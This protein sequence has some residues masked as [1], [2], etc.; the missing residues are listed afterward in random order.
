MGKRFDSKKL[1]EFRKDN[2]DDETTE[3]LL[4]VDDPVLWAE[5]HLHD[6]DLG[7]TPFVCKPQFRDVL[8]DSA[9]NRAA[10][11][12]RQQGKCSCAHTHFQLYDGSWPTA[13]EVY[14][15]VGELGAFDI[16]ATNCE[17]YKHKVDRGIIK[18]N[19]I[20]H[21]IKVATTSGHETTNTSN[22]PYFIW[23]NSWETP[24]WIEG[25]NVRVDD[26][27]A[28]TRNLSSC[29]VK[30]LESQLQPEESELLGY[31]TGDGS[32]S[33][34][35][36]KFTSVDIELI[37]RINVI[38]SNLKSNIHLQPTKAECDYL[39]VIH[40]K[41][42]HNY[43]PGRTSWITDFTK[44]HELASTLSK[45]KKVPK[46]VFT[47]DDETIAAFLG[48]Y[49]ST[50][51]WIC[52]QKTRNTT[53]IGIC[54]ASKDLIYGTRTLLLRL[55]IQSRVH[56]KKVKYDGSFKDAWQLTIQDARDIAQF[57]SM[58]PIVHIKKLETLSAAV[59]KKNNSNTDTIPKGVWNYVN[60][61]VEERKWSY[62]ELLRDS[63][64]RHERIR[65]G[66][67]PNRSKFRSQTARLDD[68]FLKAIGASDIMWDTVKKVEDKGKE[69]TYAIEV[70][71]AH[72][73]LTDNFITHNTVHLCV[74]ILHTA[75]T[76]VRSTILVFVPEKK[77]MNRMLEIMS[78]LLRGT[79]LQG[80]FRM[81]T[82]KRIKD[83][84]EPEYDYEIK[85][86]TGSVARFFFMAQKP[87][88]ARGQTGSDIYV[89]EA[90]YLPEKAWPVINGIIKA[91]P[92]IPLWA[93]STPSG[94]EDTW[95]RNFCDR[96]S[97]P[98]NK[99]GT[100]YHLP[101]T[102]EKNWK[103][104][105][106]RL[107]DLFY[108]EVSW[109]L[110]V[111]AEWAEARGAIYKKEII[112]E[113]IE[114]GAIAGR[115]LPL[116]EIRSMLEYE[117]GDKF[118]GVDWN[119]PQN[120]VRIVEITTMFG[121]PWL[122]RHETITYN[123]YTQ[124]NAVHRILELHKE[125][126]YA[127]V[128]VD[129]GYGECVHKDTLINIPEGVKRIG[130]IEKKDIVMA[131]TGVFQ[132]VTG[133]V[134]RADK[135]DAYRII[136]SKCVPTITSSTHPFLVYQTTD[137]FN[138][139]KFSE[140]ALKWKRVDAINKEKD[141]IAIPKSEYSGSTSQSLVVDIK[142]LIGSDKGFRYDDTHVWYDNSYHVRERS[143]YSK[144]EIASITGASISTVQRIRKNIKEGCP[145]NNI[146]QE[147]YTEYQKL[148]DNYPVLIKHK[149]YINILSEDFQVIYGW[150][151]SEG[152][153][154][155]SSIEISQANNHN[156]EDFDR[157]IKSSIELFGVS[158]ISLYPRKD[159][160]K[161]ASDI[162]RLFVYGKII[163]RTFETIGGK[164]APNKHIYFPLLK[165]PASL[166]TLVK[167]IFVGD[168]HT[169]SNGFE[170]SITSFHLIY[171]LRQIL[172]DC[173]ILPSLYNIPPRNLRC[174]SQIRLDVS[175]NSNVM[176]KFV[177]FTGLKY[178]NRERTNRRKYI[179]ME[180]YML[181]PISKL[182]YIGKMSGLVDIEV[183]D[184]RS[185]C[186]NG[187]A[188]HN[189]QIELLQKGFINNGVDPA[190]LLNVVDSVK[191]EKMIIEYISPETHA[192]KRNEVTVRIKT[193][194]VGLVAKYLEQDLVLPRV[195]DEY[196]TGIIK[197]IRNFRRKGMTRD[198]GFLYSDKTHSLSALQ[199]CVHGYDKF[200]SS[201]NRQTSLSHDSM[202]TNDLTEVLQAKYQKAVATHAIAVGTFSN[203]HKRK[204]RTTGLS[205]GGTRRSIL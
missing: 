135:K 175:G 66:Y 191:K 190:N 31:L 187:I 78:N 91:N 107:R 154:N 34:H 35:T 93:S 75:G 64:N 194:I 11:V 89:D 85:A 67:S 77:H 74:D 71:G 173:G 109:K 26:R 20:K 42:S 121:K 44:E 8:R 45:N 137:R 134:V 12:G 192:R 4:E 130:N 100:E 1:A 203:R 2:L 147:L 176:N 113:A 55:N 39:F 25:S 158:N 168:G 101:S 164:L 139:S 69:Q 23:R 118:L 105:E 17:S 132:E 21:V 117:R 115:F 79:D 88:K 171:Q 97:D 98:K 15:S 138:D 196:K 185:F 48:A 179:E 19:G 116:E 14:E 110:E 183:K 162:T 95:F 181:V 111:L 120:G 108:D 80:S 167:H 142:E 202:R 41:T 46:A 170:I 205:Y 143:Y 197:E 148:F 140:D 29:S 22:H 61:K 72:N 163:S 160:R 63:A 152:N 30:Q 127:I 199:F 81:G 151:L 51:G 157:L 172:I 195:E 186:G 73:L 136:P 184:S 106:A 174:L 57:Q 165:Y 60:K 156:Q 119:N 76:H 153:C 177:I 141:F 166:G 40:D 150:Y 188:L 50:D 13:K 104:I 146:Q 159:K 96:C 123:D 149:R 9:I 94:L 70:Q 3:L 92:N 112:D 65:T 90:E 38:L 58:I 122:T 53:Q 198:G 155:P 16:L 86:S 193:K 5:N 201:S 182:E 200:I 43:G 189:T 6:P 83:S 124:L 28:V 37:D 87:D 128:S 7:K 84:L 131:H 27:I 33:Q 36:I 47:S 32:T 103:E 129:A 102:L 59:V 18:D 99:N 52:N 161:N 10:R 144:Q 169:S 62:S 68:P 82:T 54:S 114:R 178:V 133:K 180:Q 126:K 125:H 56:Y 49:W 145:L 24:R 204:T